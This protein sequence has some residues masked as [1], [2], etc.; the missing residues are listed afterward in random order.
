MALSRCLV[1]ATV[2]TGLVC[3]GC[4]PAVAIGDRAGRFRKVPREY[5]LA[6]VP[7]LVLVENYDQPSVNDVDAQ[8]LAERITK[9]LTAE[10]AA[11]M[12][13]VQKVR[14]L[15]EKDRA[16]LRKM[17]IPQVGEAVGAEQV[18][19]V[20]LT[21][22]VVDS[23]ASGTIHRAIASADVRVV[24]VRTASTLWPKDVASGH[25]ITETGKWIRG[26]S[27][28]HESQIREPVYE[29]VSAAVAKLFYDHMV[30]YE[31]DDR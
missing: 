9:K 6:E 21:E 8:R 19:Y 5:R 1:L 7:T 20:N 31:L 27:L 22:F 10:N 11:P 29:K 3:S 4:G 16:A 14:D 15:R 25:P 13:P 17:T 2:L 12:V 28:Q 18:I 26:D 24:D 30:E 23:D